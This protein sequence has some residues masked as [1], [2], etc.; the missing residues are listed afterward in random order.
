MVCG[1]SACVEEY[2][3]TVPRYRG[4][5]GTLFRRERETE[6]GTQKEG[7]VSIRRIDI[8]EVSGVFSF[9]GAFHFQT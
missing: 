9:R 6:E 3:V 5:G 7:W 8:I 2:Y 1:G 4:R